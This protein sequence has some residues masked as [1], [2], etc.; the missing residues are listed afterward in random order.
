MYIKN[1]LLVPVFSV[2]AA[3]SLHAVESATIDR[4]E[5]ASPQARSFL[6]NSILGG[7]YVEVQRKGDQAVLTLSTEP[8]ISLLTSILQFSHE[9]NTISSFF[10]KESEG[11]STLEHVM[12]AGSKVYELQAKLAR[13]A[14]TLAVSE[15]LN[16]LVTAFKTLLTHEGKML[17][18][19]PNRAF[20]QSFFTDLNQHGF[21]V[22]STLEILNFRGQKYSVHLHMLKQKY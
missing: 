22:Q 16:D 4:I 7:K 17:I 9:V 13:E 21:D 18:A 14:N 6:A 2:C 19:E 1:V 5:P 3:T 12:Y 10:D 15:L 20:A 8:G 11:P